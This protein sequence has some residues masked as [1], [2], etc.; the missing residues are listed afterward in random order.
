[1]QTAWFVIAPLATVLPL[2]L[3]WWLVRVLQ[4]R[5]AAIRAGDAGHAV[6]LHCPRCNAPMQPGYV[7]AGRG[8]V[9]RRDDEKS[10]GIFTPITRALPNTINMSFGALENRAWHCANCHLVLIDHGALLRDAT[11]RD[12]A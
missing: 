11:Q 9:F 1:M 3:L 7:M 2:L 5:N 6:T 12:T 8:V 4:K 10:N